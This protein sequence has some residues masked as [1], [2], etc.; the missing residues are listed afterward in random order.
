MFGHVCMVFAKIFSAKTV[1]SLQPPQTHMAPTRVLFPTP[2]CKNRYFGLVQLCHWPKQRHNCIFASSH[3]THWSKMVGTKAT[4]FLVLRIP[5]FLLP[6]LVF[7]YTPCH[8]KRLFLL[9]LTFVKAAKHRFVYRKAVSIKK[10]ECSIY[11]SA[12]ACRQLASPESHKQAQKKLNTSQRRERTS[13]K[14]WWR[15][16]LIRAL[17]LFPPYIY[18][19]DTHAHARRRQTAP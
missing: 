13:S 18:K 7:V 11:H 16:A 6:F 2:V 9:R 4:A 1:S 12:T 5:R 3:A 17:A 8:F 19:Q 14:G 10:K 15:S